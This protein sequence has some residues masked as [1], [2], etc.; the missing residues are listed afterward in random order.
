ME[1][2]VFMMVMFFGV[3]G[4]LM[5]LAYFFVAWWV[6]KRGY[7]DFLKGWNEWRGLAYVFLALM[8]VVVAIFLVV[9]ASGGFMSNG[10]GKA[11]GKL[12]KTYSSG[13]VQETL[14]DLDA[15]ESGAITFTKLSGSNREE[16]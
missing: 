16:K 9:M 10:M 5:C 14:K 8:Q 12:A 1:A 7:D 3:I 4:N 15:V 6:E 11:K 13:L 2:L